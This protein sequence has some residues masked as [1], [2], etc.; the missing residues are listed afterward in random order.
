MSKMR[1]FFKNMTIIS[2][3]IA[4]ISLIVYIIRYT[5][6]GVGF[7]FSWPQPCLWELVLGLIFL[8]LFLFWPKDKEKK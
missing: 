8:L 4:F 7:L 2:W 5:A 6:S 3:G 1:M